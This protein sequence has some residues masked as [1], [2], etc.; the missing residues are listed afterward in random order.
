MISLYITFVTSTDL[1][2]KLNKTV[3]VVTP[4]EKYIDTTKY[5]TVYQC[6]F[7]N[8]SSNLCLSLISS[9]PQNTYPVRGILGAKIQQNKE[10]PAKHKYEVKIYIL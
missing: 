10:E 4:Y 9:S 5:L 1:T 7:E 8:T 6:V 2:T 3:E